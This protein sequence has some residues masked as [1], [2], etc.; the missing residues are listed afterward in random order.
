MEWESSLQSPV[1]EKCSECFWHSWREIYKQSD[2]DTTQLVYRHLAVHISLRLRLFPHFCSSKKHA[3]HQTCKNALGHYGLRKKETFSG[4]LKGLNRFCKHKGVFCQQESL[5]NNMLAE[6]SRLV[7]TL[8]R[9]IPATERG[10]LLSDP[11]RLQTIANKH[12]HL[13]LDPFLQKKP[14]WPLRK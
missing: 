8:K 10:I 13:E 9:K 2:R 4:K 3:C 12:K 1:E 14:Y 5:P 11:T 6:F 7:G